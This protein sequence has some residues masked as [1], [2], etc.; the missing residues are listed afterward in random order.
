MSSQQLAFCSPSKFD[1][2]SSTTSL[3]MTP[4]WNTTPNF[5]IDDMLFIGNDDSSNK[6]LRVKHKGLLDVTRKGK[7]IAKNFKRRIKQQILSDLG[8]GER[9]IDT[10]LKS[11][12]PIETNSSEAFP[13]VIEIKS[14]SDNSKLQFFELEFMQSMIDSNCQNQNTTEGKFFNKST[15]DQ[16]HDDTKSPNIR[17]RCFKDAETFKNRFMFNLPIPITSKKSLDN[18]NPFKEL[19]RYSSELDLGSTPKRTSSITDVALDY[20][21]SPAVMMRTSSRLEGFGDYC[22]V[23]NIG[24]ESR[25]ETEFEVLGEIG[26]GHFGVVKRCRNRLD[27]LE[28]AVKIANNK[29]RGEYGKREALQEVFALSALSVCDD[30]PYIVKYF[31]GWIEDSKLYIVVIQNLNLD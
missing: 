2:N 29:W 9:M 20:S 13:Q 24:S 28:Y 6:G 5:C 27:G 4:E 8:A 7:S 21:R 31:Y 1:N 14:S 19:T 12:S 17:E 25:F 30:N 15:P 26:K 3:P 16:L 10:I 18:T 23:P 11:D 22:E